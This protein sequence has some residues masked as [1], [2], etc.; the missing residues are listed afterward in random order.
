MVLV[1]RTVLILTLLMCSTVA[2]Q[3]SIWFITGRPILWLVKTQ[4]S[5][6]CDNPQL[7]NDLDLC[8]T[9]F[10]PGTLEPGTRVRELPDSV[11]PCTDL[12]GVRVLDGVFRGNVGCVA[13]ENLTQV[14]PQ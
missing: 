2:A 14:K 11:S 12:V 4:K 6:I 3:G 5:H 9:T 8:D 13:A 1:A 7:P 10:Q